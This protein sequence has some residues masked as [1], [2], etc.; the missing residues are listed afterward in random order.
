MRSTKTRPSQRPAGGSSTGGVSLGM[1]SVLC[2]G[3]VYCW[4]H[5]LICPTQIVPRELNCRLCQGN[6]TLV[7]SARDSNI[8]YYIN[9]ITKD[10]GSPT[11]VV[12]RCTQHFKTQV[13]EVNMNANQDSWVS[14]TAMDLAISPDNKF[15]LVATGENK[16]PFT[17]PTY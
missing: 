8:L 17:K 4:G 10:V 7:A 15:L 5:A 1:S 12:P 13:V 16:S 14:F 9:C 2:F 11:V 6:E 3:S